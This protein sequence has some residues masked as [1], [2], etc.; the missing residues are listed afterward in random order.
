ML[1]IDVLLLL[2]IF[3]GMFQ[4]NVNSVR[5]SN[6]SALVSHVSE[7]LKV[8]MLHKS[9]NVHCNKCVRHF[10]TKKGHI[11]NINRNKGLNAY[12]FQVNYTRKSSPNRA[13]IE[14]K[15][16]TVGTL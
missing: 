9:V 14:L 4:Y 15:D 12:T 6:M 13:I 16:R 2:W 10:I 8:K 5:A 11:A 3:V 7:L 1:P